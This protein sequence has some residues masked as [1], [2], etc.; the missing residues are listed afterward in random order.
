MH[1]YKELIVW[2]KSI[3]LVKITYQL[4]EKF[5]DKEKY[6]LS[7]QIQRAA[8]SIPSNI[9]EGAGRN[10]EKAFLNYLSIANASSCELETQLIIA[11]ELNYISNEDAKNAFDFI[12]EIQKMIFAFHKNH[13]VI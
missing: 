3:K 2:Q 9:A 12:F 11:K 10:S 6:G 8:V 13:A 1:K 4:T 7:Q 5:P